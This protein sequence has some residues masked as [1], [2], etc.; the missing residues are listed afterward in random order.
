M[1]VTE[2]RDAPARHEPFMA[3]GALAVPLHRLRRLSPQELL[4]R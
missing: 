1:G 4:R 3:L 2:P